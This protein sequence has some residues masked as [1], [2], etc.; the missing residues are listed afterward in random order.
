MIYFK[1]R[2]ILADAG[3]NSNAKWIGIKNAA[4]TGKGKGNKKRG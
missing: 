2:I 1:R 4:K 3:A